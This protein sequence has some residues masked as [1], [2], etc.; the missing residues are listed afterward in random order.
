MWSLAHILNWYCVMF[1]IITYDSI[2]NQ[3]IALNKSFGMVY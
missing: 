1:Y 2:K 3:I